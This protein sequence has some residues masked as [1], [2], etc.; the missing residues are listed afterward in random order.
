MTS[1]DSDRLILIAFPKKEMKNLA[2]LT[3]FV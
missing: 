2:A 3:P 1:L